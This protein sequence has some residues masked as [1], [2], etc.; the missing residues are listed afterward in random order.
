VLRQAGFG[1]KQDG[2]TLVFA[3]LAL[4]LVCFPLL[5][6]AADVRT[7]QTADGKASVAAFMG[8]K[9]GAEQPDLNAVNGTLRSTSQLKL[10]EAKAVAACENAV[11]VA[12]PGANPSCAVQDGRVTVVVEGPVRLPIPMPFGVWSTVRERAKAQAALGTVTVY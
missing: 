2:Q 10:A 12:D 9:A 3:A 8:A 1:G 7:Q 5:G 6:V 4:T 11:R